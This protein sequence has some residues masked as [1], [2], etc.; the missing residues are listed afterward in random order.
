LHTNV[1]NSLDRLAPFI[2]TEWHF[3]NSQ[4]KNLQKILSD[5]DKEIFNLDT[6][7]LDWDDYFDSMAQ[8]VRRYLNNE[9]PRTLPAAKRKSS[10]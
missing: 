1:D 2:F 8:G 9:H 7:R 6:S 5:E 10:V 3:Q 4:T